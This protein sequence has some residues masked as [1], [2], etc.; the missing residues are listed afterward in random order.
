MKSWESFRSDLNRTI[1]EIGQEIIDESKV[2]Y[3]STCPDCKET[4]ITDETHSCAK[5]VLSARK[6]R[7][8]ASKNEKRNKHTGEH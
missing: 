4:Y 3:Y 7:L 8:F 5:H 2:Q 6:F 1:K